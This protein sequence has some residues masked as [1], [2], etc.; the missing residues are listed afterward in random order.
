LPFL[1]YPWLYLAVFAVANPLIFRW[2]LAPP[3]PALML[4]IVAGLW[5]VAR[6]L[7]KRRIVGLSA[8][9]AI[10]SLV[11]LLWLFMSINGWE[12]HPNHGPDRPAP[13]MAWHEI[14]L[15]YQDVGT[16]L[17]EDYGVTPETR[18]SSADIG[19]V[20]YFSRATIVDTVGLVTPELVQYYPVDPA[21]IPDAQNYAIPP[22]LILDTDPAYLV[23]MEAF[24]RL[25]LEQIDEFQDEY[26]LAR[27][28]PT[29]FYGTGMRLYQRRDMPTAATD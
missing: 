22:Q 10:M 29:N 24:V 16:E 12:L 8:S 4:G 21:L 3:M 5:S 25:G 9:A 1:L 11:G 13:K 15:L 17:R 20:G 18:V 23:T 7:D 19:A 28:I 14:E 6:R 2:Y 27:E 26:E